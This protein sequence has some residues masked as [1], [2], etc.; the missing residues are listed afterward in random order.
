M[1]WPKNKKGMVD[2]DLGVSSEEVGLAVQEITPQKLL[3]AS[4][5]I[6]VVIAIGGIFQG[7]EWI[8]P[9]IVLILAVVF[10]KIIFGNLKFISLIAPFVVM[11]NLMLPGG[12]VTNEILSGGNA[13][14]AILSNVPTIILMGISYATT[15]GEETEGFQTSGGR[16]IPGAGVKGGVVAYGV[17][18]ILFILR[19]LA[20]LASIGPLEFFFNLMTFNMWA[21]NQA[22][23]GVPGLGPEAGPFYNILSYL[24]KATLLIGVFLL[25]DYPARIVAPTVFSYTWM[26]G[27]GFI[28][29][30][31]IIWMPFLV[32]NPL[33]RSSFGTV[34][35]A[36]QGVSQSLSNTMNNIMMPITN[37]EAYQL[38]QQAQF[39]EG[40]GL[41]GNIGSAPPNT[42][43]S[44]KSIQLLPDRI[45]LFT[46]QTSAVIEVSNDGDADIKT[47]NIT[48][49]G[50]IIP[51][52]LEGQRVL[53]DCKG[54]GRATSYNISETVWKWDDHLVVNDIP[55]GTSVRVNCEVIEIEGAL[56][57]DAVRI[58][59]E[60]TTEY[61]TR[62]LYPISVIESQYARER[63]EQGLMSF[64]N[65]K[66]TVSYGTITSS[67]SVG[68]QPLF[69]NTGATLFTW[70]VVNAGDGQV[71]K[72]DKAYLTVPQE[73]SDPGRISNQTYCLTE[74]TTLNPEKT[75]CQGGCA[76]GF[77]ELNAQQ[78]A[79]ID[80]SLILQEVRPCGFNAC[81]A[82][83]EKYC[84]SS[85]DSWCCQNTYLDDEG[86]SHNVVCGESEEAPCKAAD[87][88]EVY[89]D[90]KYSAYEVPDTC[91]S[92]RRSRAGGWFLCERI[93]EEPVSTKEFQ[94]YNE[95]RN[96]EDGLLPITELTGKIDNDYLVESLETLSS[97][98]YVICESQLPYIEE[99]S[100]Y[101][102]PIFIE[103]LKSQKEKTYLIRGDVFYSYTKSSGAQGTVVSR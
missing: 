86:A 24:I 94:C 34:A 42:G 82:G 75:L 91:P 38:Q 28:F 54:R 89:T 102:F 83:Q 84:T 1:A 20:F 63:M 53:F 45:N 29:F 49:T 14:L 67:Q 22:I 17:I 39:R 72:V 47:M 96:D 61:Y 36:S 95:T 40:G 74:G 10:S 18:A 87:T 23:P 59:A 15:K 41:V 32:T 60:A 7:L 64:S 73:L 4:I 70:G 19:I 97:M 57:G 92:N 3:A 90:I 55:K 11:G 51:G 81:R 26:L 50:E 52:G 35:G 80:S 31:A 9:W 93:S 30:Y 8:F 103:E 76:E 66:T 37:P 79:Q 33:I 44:I 56:E 100:L 62:T 71:H 69:D 13:I 68:T 78:L 99:G 6:M 25:A 58:E 43:F 48:F 101:R 88:G 98:G 27:V 65:P 85:D 46:N 77:Y 5:T 12:G 2:L 21:P 16:S